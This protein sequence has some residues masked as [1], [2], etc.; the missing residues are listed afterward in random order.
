[1]LV[2]GDIERLQR[3]WLQGVCKPQ[4]QKRNAS[5]PLDINQFM[6]AFLL[7]GCGVLLT[8]LLLGLE[9]VYFLYVRKHL[10]K[11]DNGG[12]F[13]LLSLVLPP[14]YLPHYLPHYFHIFFTI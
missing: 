4:N 8:L 9:H 10:S 11:K 3:F 7:L 6:S 14:H 5:N 2:A 12:C 1:M 13:T